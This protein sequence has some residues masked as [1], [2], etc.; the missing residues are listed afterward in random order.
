MGVTMGP[1]MRRV[2]AAWE[3]AGEPPEPDTLALAL[4]ITRDALRRHELVLRKLGLIETR[5]APGR[6]TCASEKEANPNAAIRVCLG[7]TRTFLSE[8]IGNR[9]CLSCRELDRQG[10]AE[11]FSLTLNGRSRVAVG[12]GVEDLAGGPITDEPEPDAWAT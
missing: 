11:D 8:W 5:R 2:F 4:K 1:V 7:C 6:P 12:F 3:A 10:T 9:Q